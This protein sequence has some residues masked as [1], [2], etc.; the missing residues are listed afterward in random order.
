M[1]SNSNLLQWHLP[2]NLT[3]GT[4]SGH[5]RT[6]DSLVGPGM[7]TGSVSVDMMGLT[8]RRV[9]I[10]GRCHCKRFEFEFMHPS[11]E[12]HKVM[13]CNC[14]MCT[15]KGYLNVYMPFEYFKF[16]KGTMEELSVYKIDSSEEG[17]HR[18]CPTC[19]C[20]VVADGGGIAV[21]SVRSLDPPVD[22]DSLKVIKFNG[23]AI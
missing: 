22:I 21:V 1:N 17:G 6:P 14:T 5:W 13:N 7:T 8:I 3:D 20:P 18:F 2:L 15:R 23:L 12:Q 10:K 11:L 19:G 4:P 16:T 9:K